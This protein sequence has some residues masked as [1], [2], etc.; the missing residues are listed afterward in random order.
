M[1]NDV[2][3]AEVLSH[4]TTFEPPPN[5]F[6]PLT[7]TSELLHKHGFPHRPHPRK[8]PRLSEIWQ[9]TFSR[10]LSVI[11]AELAVDRTSPRRNPLR[12]RRDDD[13]FGLAGQWAG[14]QVNIA[15]LGFD[16]QTE[17]ATTV[18]GRWTVPTVVAP[19]NSLP[20][21][22]AVG[23]WV[24]LGGDGNNNSTNV[25]QAGIQGK[26]NGNSV[27]Y[28]AWTQWFPAQ[29]DAV[30][31][32]NFDV[33]PGDV[34]EVLVVCQHPSNHAFASVYNLRTN[35]A[36]SV[37]IDVGLKNDGTSAEWIVEGNGALLA[38]FFSANFPGAV[39]GECT[40]GTKQH[41]FTVNQ[42]VVDMIVSS[43]GITPL[44]K[45]GILPPFLGNGTVVN[46]LSAGP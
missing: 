6:D 16:P 14:A 29:L 21:K 38:E 12:R 35:H 28:S 41:E 43:N 30:T 24:G 15:D 40:G 42:G 18:Y 22:L 44:A 13:A 32:P 1:S 27:E 33:A 9:R 31:I 5:G 20:Q 25:V 26:V 36:T 17:P 8:E 4:F 2:S 7:A 11:R 46:W 3:D 34:V 23:F 45:G 39:C 37:G 19:P 10:P